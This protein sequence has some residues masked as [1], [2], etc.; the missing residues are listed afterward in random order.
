MRPISII[1]ALLGVF[2]MDAAELIA[3]WTFDSRENAVVRE[4]TGKNNGII[5]GNVDAMRIDKAFDGG[6]FYFEDG[7]AYVEVASSD[8]ISLVNDATF[9]AT[10]KPASV[11]GYCTIFWKGSRKVT[12]EAISYYLNLRDGK[13]EFK[14]KKKDGNWISWV[15]ADAC[16]PADRWSVITATFKDG[17]V[18][19][20]V[21]GAEKKLNIPPDT[22]ADKAFTELIA[23]EHPLYFG[24]AQGSGGYPAYHFRGLIDEVAFY[25]G[26]DIRI[27][28]SRVPVIAC[29]TLAD[30]FADAGRNARKQA[31]SLRS[32]TAE[33]DRSGLKAKNAAMEAGNEAT[34]AIADAHRLISETMNDLAPLMERSGIHPAAVKTPPQVSSIA[35]MMQS[36]VSLSARADELR[37][38]AAELAKRMNDASASDTALITEKASTAAEVLARAFS[39]MSAW[40]ARAKGAVREARLFSGN[41][42]FA[43]AAVPSAVT[44]A[45]HASM[46]NVLDDLADT[47]SVSLAR[48]E[49]E[50]TQIIVFPNPRSSAAVPIRLSVST[51]PAGVTVTVAPMKSVNN[52]RSVV[53]VDHRGPIFDVILDGETET[54]IPAGL[55]RALYVRIGADE[56][57]KA[58]MY[59]MTVSMRSDNYTK[60]FP[61]AVTVYD[62]TLPKK[63]SLKVAFSF[64]EQ[65]YAAWFKYGPLTDEQRMGIYRFINAYRVA[66][67]NIYANTIFPDPKYLPELPDQNFATLGYFGPHNKKLSDEEIQAFAK[68]TAARL[69]ALSNA[70]FSMSDAYLYCFD[71]YAVFVRKHF[72]AD[73]VRR[74]SAYML[75]EFP[76]IKLLQTSVPDDGI[77]DLFNAWVSPIE[78]FELIKPEYR[79]REN[80]EFWWYWVSDPR[81][82]PNFF[83]G[84]PNIENRMAMLIAFKY[85]VP[86]CLY[87]CINR[88]WP[89]N[90]AKSAEWPNAEWDAK[91]VNVFT[92]Q[93]NVQSGQG[94]LI[95]PGKNGSIYPSIR[96]EN[97]RDGIEDYDYLALLRS[98]AGE[99]R[100]G[101]R[102]KHASRLAEIDALLAMPSEVVE[103]LSHW[104]KDNA[105]LSAYR[106]K[107][108]R[109]IETISN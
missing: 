72:D 109:M 9:T 5:Q 88:E 49:R 79:K 53:P 26:T 68:D 76:G 57:A 47:A 18:G 82:F 24:A 103:S 97:L 2:T 92:K 27:G 50:G 98:L 23:N 80:Y 14:V 61:I 69:A 31:A 19:I 101:K 87:W 55:P 91:Y 67:N 96:F 99:I 13:V 83:L 36:A 44:L 10:I 71:E 16:V 63:S 30:T 46:F 39:D 22:A 43:A 54:V 85:A 62:F 102:Q 75:K 35:D 8:D 29:H 106:E 1:C 38:L 33:I 89:D 65:N 41:A 56:K 60:E 4:E 93:D 48:G 104:T 108:A 70:G 34:A 74:F 66:P 64:F 7:K 105:V 45:E 107:V 73:S 12:P 77:I 40:N 100:S 94:N 6:A 11:A 52:T 28:A 84:Y 81:P 90:T 17:I 51:P 59:R 58:G 3:R 37:T 78:S 42:P 21:N 32:L 95:Y 86:G 20:A 25:R 15:T